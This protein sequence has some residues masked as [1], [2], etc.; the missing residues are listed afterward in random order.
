MEQRPNTRPEREN[1]VFPGGFILLLVIGA[2]AV[3]VAGLI[4][5]VF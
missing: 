3:I 4:V 5:F 2:I 1:A